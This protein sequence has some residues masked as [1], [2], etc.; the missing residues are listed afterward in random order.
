MGYIISKLGN[1]IEA[2]R[3]CCLGVIK[4]REKLILSTGGSSEPARW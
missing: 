3:L 4:M 2:G 1:E